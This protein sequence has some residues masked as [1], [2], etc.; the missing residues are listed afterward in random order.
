MGKLEFWNDDMNPLNK[1]E[2]LIDD[3]NPLNTIEIWNY[4]DLNK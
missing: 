1:I 3:Y 2:I 4:I